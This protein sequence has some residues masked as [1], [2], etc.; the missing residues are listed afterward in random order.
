MCTHAGCDKTFKLARD[1]KRHMVMHTNERPYKCTH[2]GCGATFAWTRN[3]KAHMITHSGLKPYKC[4]HAA[5]GYAF[6]WA[7]GLNDHMMT[8]TEEYAQRRKKEE[9]RIADVLTRHGIAFKREHNI[10]FSCIDSSSTYARID[11]LVLLKGV[12]IFLEV[13]E[14]QHKFRYT[15][16]CELKRMARSLESLACEGNTMPIVFIRYNPHAYQLG[17]R[18]GPTKDRVTREQALIDLLTGP[19]LLDEN[20]PLKIVYMF[21]D[22]DK[23]TDGSLR[24]RIHSDPEYNELMKKC[25][26]PPIV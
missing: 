5:C 1:L 17:D 14:G 23:M 24:P 10:D 16:S 13:D 11:F 7:R 25:C 20:S 22:C 12:T 9:Q 2:V 19:S 18:P 15:V 8:H 4:P 3:L 21:Y 26:T 6:A